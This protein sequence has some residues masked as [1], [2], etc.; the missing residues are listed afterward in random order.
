MG[1]S[2]FSKFPW[3]SRFI[4]I[5]YISKIIFYIFMKWYLKLKLIQLKFNLSPVSGGW[6]FWSGLV[7][8]VLHSRDPMFKIIDWVSLALTCLSSYRGPSNGYQKLLG[9]WWSIVNCLL[10][11]TWQPWGGWTLSTKRRHKVSFKK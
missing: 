10:V 11:L 7:V 8:R 9:T 5:S 3:I 1:I 6:E 2:L 4:V